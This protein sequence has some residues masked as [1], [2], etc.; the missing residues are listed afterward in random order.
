MTDR[1]PEPDV[2]ISASYT[3]KSLRFNKKTRARTRVEW[4]G[5]VE[6]LTEGEREGLPED[7]EVGKTYR[8][9]RG[10]KTVA[11]RLRKP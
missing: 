2:S 10:G 1:E 4:R 8:N 9:V 3:A 11:A 6:D 7:P 5:D